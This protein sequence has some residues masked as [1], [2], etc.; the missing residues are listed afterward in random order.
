MTAAMAKPMTPMTGDKAKVLAGINAMTAQG[1]T[2]IN[3]GAMW[4]YRMLSP[5]WRGFWGGDMLANKLPLDYNSK[6][7]SKAAVIMTDGENSFTPK[8]YGAYGYLSD[9]RLGTT[10]RNTAEDTLDARLTAACN[11]MKTNNIMVITIAY[12]NP[13]AATK[14]LLENC[15][16]NT[17]LYFD[18]KS[19]SDLIAKFD[20][21][22]GALSKLRV[23]K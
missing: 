14:T 18:A 11:A 19:T 12:D 23:S 4:G 1:S 6:N 17:S 22:R 13:K 15:A 5:R 20:L 21:I 2:F 10:D 8:F 7:M 3:V 9:N 16:T